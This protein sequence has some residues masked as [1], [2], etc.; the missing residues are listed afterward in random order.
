MT[1]AVLEAPPPAASR[2]WEVILLLALLPLALLAAA[3]GRMLSYGQP[4]D[5]LMFDYPPSRNLFN[6]PVMT[7]TR[8]AVAG[9]DVIFEIP[10]APV[11]VL[12]L[13]HGCAHSAHDFWYRQPGCEQCSGLPGEVSHTKQA[14]ALGYA[15]VAINSVSRSTNKTD[16]SH[17]CFSFRN[18]RE[19]VVAIL[20]TL[21]PSLGLEGLPLFLGGVSS[22]ASF[23]LKL[24]ASLRPGEVSG[25]F[26]E[27]LGV[28]PL[29]GQFDWAKWPPV[30]FI[31]M[32]HD[33]AAKQRVA[34]NQGA[35]RQAGVRAETLQ[36]PQRAVYPAFFSDQ[37]ADISPQLS[38]RLVEG[39]TELGVLDQEGWMAADPKWGRDLD[40]RA[41]LAQL[42]P[43]MDG[44]SPASSLEL[45]ASV[46]SELLNTAYSKHDV[47]GDYVTAALRWLHAGAQGDL[48]QLAEEY[49]IRRPALLTADRLQPGEKPATSGDPPVQPLAAL[50]A[51]ARLE[52]SLGGAT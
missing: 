16:R 3:A 17:R 20:R 6:Q 9:R 31:T 23:A 49:I 24:P 32:Q 39:L 5:R 13:F 52:R 26:A 46:A 18:D 43:E 8:V 21:L 48:A 7:A 19:G 28:D 27:L 10:Q 51:H 47:V 33:E 38:Q 34:R 14:L 41:Q 37:A 4:G 15:V 30:A 11:G 12:A 22:G 25:I 2:R 35:L 45:D 44:S 42:V 29:K 40:W 50:T 1:A 36:V